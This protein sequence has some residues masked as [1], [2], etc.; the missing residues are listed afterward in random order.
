MPP[1]DFRPAAKATNLAAMARA[2]SGA[3]AQ[4]APRRPLARCHSPRTLPLALLPAWREGGGLWPGVRWSTL[5]FGDGMGAFGRP[6]DAHAG[7]SNGRGSRKR[8]STLAVMRL[9][10]LS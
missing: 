3:M 1:H 4:N 5:A 9:M 6:G 7:A 2:K 8:R 10:S